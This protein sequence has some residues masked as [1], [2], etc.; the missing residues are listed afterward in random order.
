M[1]RR[2]LSAVSVA[3]LS[4]LLSMGCGG[5]PESEPTNLDTQ[6][7]PLT[8]ELY[9]L[10]CDTIQPLKSTRYPPAVGSNYVDTYWIYPGC[11][12]VNGGWWVTFEVTMVACWSG[13]GTSCPKFEV[14]DGTGAVL[15]TYTSSSATDYVRISAPT[16]DTIFGIRFTQPTW[17]PSTSATSVKFN[18]TTL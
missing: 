17:L 12:P 8:A 13:D 18:I 9:G 14:L 5:S 15:K 11:N 4:L 2:Q 3:S 1:N 7:I 6:G 10:A 16:P